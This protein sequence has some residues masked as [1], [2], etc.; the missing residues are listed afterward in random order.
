MKEE[1]LKYRYHPRVLELRLALIKAQIE[2]QYGDETSMIYL[3]QM[4]EMFQCNWSLLVGIFMKDHKIISNPNIPAKRRKQETIFMGELY[5]ETRHYI[6]N[7]YLKMS[8]N[9]LYQS[10][11]EHSPEHFATEEWLKELDGE[12]V[13]IGVRAYALEAKRFV[14]AFDSLVGIFK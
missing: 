3:K 2:R 7:H 6:S 1:L 4:A 13:A 12:V 5:N 10:K 14:I 9:Y 8:S 11:G